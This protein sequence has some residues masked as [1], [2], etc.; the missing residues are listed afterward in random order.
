MS[1]LEELLR[2]TVSDKDTTLKVFEPTV[3]FERLH[4]PKHGH[5][6]KYPIQILQRMRDQY[7]AVKTLRDHFGED[8]PYTTE[9]TFDIQVNDVFAMEIADYIRNN[10]DA[11]LSI[12]ISP[13]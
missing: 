3:F 12:D 6:I 7:E 9:Y 1:G 5:G 10:Y 8:R 13:R 2:I 11:S 4:L